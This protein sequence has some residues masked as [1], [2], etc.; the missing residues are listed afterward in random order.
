MTQKLIFMYSLLNSQCT[1]A[2]IIYNDVVEAIVFP[3]F[4]MK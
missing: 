3:Y 1:L 2:N 4:T